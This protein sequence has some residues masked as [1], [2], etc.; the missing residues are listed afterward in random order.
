MSRPRR[1]S[2]CSRLLHPRFDVPG[3]DPFCAGLPHEPLE[4]GE[5]LRRRKA[6]QR[7]RK[8]ASEQG[9]RDLVGRAR[10]AVERAGG[11]LE[12][13]GVVG[14]DL[15]RPRGRIGDRLAVAGVGD[16][17]SELLDAGQGLRGSRRAGRA[18]NPDR[19]R[20]PA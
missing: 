1:L 17:G 12:P 5:R 11:V 16:P 20:S 7:G 18:A 8:L 19:G 14:P 9:Q 4:V 10:R 6:A 13:L 15:A 3:P 2:P